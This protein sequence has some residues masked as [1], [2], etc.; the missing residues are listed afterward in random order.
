MVSVTVS[1]SASLRTYEQ[2]GISEI[3]GE[4]GEMLSLLT[5]GSV[6]MVMLATVVRLQ[7]RR[8]VSRAVQTSPFAVR[9]NNG[10]TGLGRGHTI[11]E[12]LIG[13]GCSLSVW[14]HWASC[15]ADNVLDVLAGSGVIVPVSCVGAPLMVSPV[16]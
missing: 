15:V 14:I 5:D 3:A 11:F 12:P 9:K 13:V 4:F 6:A 1:P 2:V 16:F 7:N 8:L 10:L